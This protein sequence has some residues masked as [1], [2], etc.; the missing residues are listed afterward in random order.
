MQFK[1]SCSHWNLWSLMKLKHNFIQVWN[2]AW[3]GSIST[4][5]SLFC[6]KVANLGTPNPPTPLGLK[7]NRL[8]NYIACKMF[9]VQTLLRSLEFV[10]HDKSWVQH[11]S[12]PP[13]LEKNWKTFLKNWV[14]GG[15]CFLKN[16]WGNQKY[17]H[18]RGKGM[19]FFIFTFFLLPIIVTDTA[20]SLA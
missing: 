9:A 4:S 12:L 8:G 11:H 20:Y 2:L 5:M 15:N 7:S 18:F 13:P 19:N 3:N 17:K 6:N 14:T 1:F 16:W 10:I